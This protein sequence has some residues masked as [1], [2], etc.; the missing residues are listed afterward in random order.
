MWIFLREGFLSVIAAPEDGVL[1]VRSRVR[2][3][4][5]RLR[6]LFALG[7]IVEGAGTDY[8]YR[9]SI[10]REAFADGLAA[11]AMEID[12]PNFKNEVAR[13]LG[14]RRE[15]T[16]HKVWSILFRELRDEPGSPGGRSDG[17]PPGRHPLP[18]R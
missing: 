18:R 8:K 1:T 11:C 4:L 10:T 2:A 6:P 3:D 17:E 15:R 12:Y 16:Y 9:A 13:A 7:P 5:E 14:A